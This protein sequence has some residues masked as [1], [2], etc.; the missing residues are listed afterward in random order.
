MFL[1][2]DFH[3]KKLFKNRRNNQE[4][5]SPFF[6]DTNSLLV[7]YLNKLIF[8]E[9]KIE[10]ERKKL[11]KMPLFNIKNFFEKIAL[12]NKNYITLNNLDFYLKNFD[13]GREELNLLLNRFDKDQDSKISYFKVKIN[14]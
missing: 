9:N 1:P 13:L 11:N 6:S 5:Q 10:I 14:F 3:Y 7:D 2:C 8:I 12:E 4:S